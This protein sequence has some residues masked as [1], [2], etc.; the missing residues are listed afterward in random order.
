MPRMNRDRALRL[1]EKK[2]LTGC[3]ETRRSRNVPLPPG[4]AR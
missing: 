2:G 3:T 4:E 1:I